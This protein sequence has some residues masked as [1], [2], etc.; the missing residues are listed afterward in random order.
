MTSNLQPQTLIF[1]VHKRICGQLN[2][3]NQALLGSPVPIHN[4]IQCSDLVWLLQENESNQV[5]HGYAD[6][7]L[8]IFSSRYADV[9]YTEDDLED[10]HEQKYIPDVLLS[11]YPSQVKEMELEEVID[12]N[13][14]NSE[15]IE[16]PGYGTFVKDLVTTAES[17]SNI[18]TEKLIEEDA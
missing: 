12:S 10:E 15:N 9:L 14:I 2:N 18:D 13:E 16:S 11:C 1:K 8:L 5:S 6:L 17:D 7:L 4:D 3:Q